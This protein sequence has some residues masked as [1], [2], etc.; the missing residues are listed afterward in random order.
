MGVESED[1][2]RKWNWSWVWWR[3]SYHIERRSGR[4]AFA[5][6]EAQCVTYHTFHYIFY[7]PHVGDIHSLSPLSLY[8]FQRLQRDVC[9]ETIKM[10]IWLSRA[11]VDREHRPILILYTFGKYKEVRLKSSSRKAC[12]EP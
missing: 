5:E 10:L 1:L 9:L 11:S 7:E 12:K 4:R 8:L 2:W 3:E 6:M